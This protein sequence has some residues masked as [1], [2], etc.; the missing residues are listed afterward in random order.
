MA[1]IHCAVFIR[2]WSLAIDITKVKTFAVEYKYFNDATSSGLQ[3]TVCAPRDNFREM[4]CIRNGRVP[5]VND[6]CC[7]SFI[8]VPLDILVALFE[9]LIKLF[10]E[11]NA[12][13]ASPSSLSFSFTEFSFRAIVSLSLTLGCCRTIFRGHT[14][15]L[16]RV[17]ISISTSRLDQD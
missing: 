2:S 8:R 15:S 14:S 1:D 11:E 3:K 4:L 13:I 17:N 16:E 9:N 5:G 12:P 6:S 7:Y 10:F